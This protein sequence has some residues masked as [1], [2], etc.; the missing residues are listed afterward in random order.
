[1]NSQDLYELINSLTPHEKRYFK[2]DIAKQG[3]DQKQYVL[4]FELIDKNKSELEKQI[5]HTF[6][7][8]KNLTALKQYL[9]DSLL[10]SLQNYHSKKHIRLQLLDASQKLEILIMKGLYRQAKKIIDKILKIST[11]QHEDILKLYSLDA[12]LKIF[13]ELLRQELLLDHNTIFQELFGLLDQL[14]KDKKLAAMACRLL[15]MNHRQDRTLSQADRN[16]VLQLIE[17]ANQLKINQLNAPHVTTRLF[18]FL[19]FAHSML[20]NNKTAITYKIK[21]IQNIQQSEQTDQNTTNR[22]LH[23]IINLIISL[24]RQQ[25][26]EESEYWLNELETAHQQI[27][28]SKVRKIHFEDRFQPV[29][30]RC[31]L[32]TLSGGFER[33]IH[34]IPDLKKEWYADKKLSTKYPLYFLNLNYIFAYANF[35]V[36]NFEV[37]LDWLEELRKIKKLPPKHPTNRASK[38]LEIAVHFELGNYILLESLIRSYQRWLTK[39][40]NPTDFELMMLEYFKQLIKEIPEQKDLYSEYLPIFQKQKKDETALFL[41]EYFDPVSWLEAKINQSTYAQAY[42]KNVKLVN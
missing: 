17:E 10:K 14:Q 21:S 12:Q 15:V 6:G 41:R 27:L 37:A 26:W 16:A 20:G 5:Q 38:I 25:Q 4:L 2:L 13:R 18:Q 35:A 30:L 22:Y 28:K 40:Q 7:K 42:R 29:N 32:Y 31:Y 8:G 34:L 19:G 23:Q 3:G 36:Q 39:L 24:I 9:Y 11:Q 33:I 1:M